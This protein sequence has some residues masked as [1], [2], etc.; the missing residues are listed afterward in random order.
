MAERRSPYGPHVNG[1]EARRS[2]TWPSGMAAGL[3]GVGGGQVCPQTRK[4]L[5]SVALKRK[6]GRCWRKLEGS[7]ML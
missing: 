5:C 6:G 1:R 3:M 7:G 2:E 4:D